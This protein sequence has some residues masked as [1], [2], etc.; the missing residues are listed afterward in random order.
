MTRLLARSGEALF[1]KAANSLLTYPTLRKLI[2]RWS[3]N[4]FSSKARG[5]AW[6]FLN[7]G[8]VCEAT[9]K[10]PEL[11]ADDEKNRLCIQLYHLLSGFVD[12]RGR[13]VLEVG[14]GRGGGS[15]YIAK[16][17]E[18][19]L[20]T[21]MDLSKNAIRYC[22]ERHVARNTSYQVGAAE[23]LP[24]DDDRFDVVLNIES[25]HCYASVEKFFHEVARVLKTDGIFF[26]AD[27]NAARNDDRR[28][29]NVGSIVVPSTL[30]LLHE[31][32]ITRK[33]VP[34]MDL[35]SDERER[36]LT[37]MFPGIFREATLEDFGIKGTEFYR[38]MVEGRIIYLVRV[39]KKVL[40]RISP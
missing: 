33:V 16:Y 5:P 14:C 6:D 13:Q 7:F 26:W 38:D 35:L 17:L 24:F 11:D 3:Y 9:E 12:V 1:V 18:P 37:D 34:A 31:E 39:Y 27:V 28:L 19:A 29:S 8:Y 15:A 32:D 4:L 20:I 2:W 30:K 40:P 23:N 36:A 22:R 21:G 25:S 10:R